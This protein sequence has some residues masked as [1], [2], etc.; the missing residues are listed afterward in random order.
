MTERQQQETFNDWIHAHRALLYKVIRSYAVDEDDQDD[1]FQE[2]IVQVWRS[3]PNFRNDCAVTT[4]M[5]RIALNTSM[6]W[7]NKT[8]RH[9]DNHQSLEQSSHIID[10]QPVKDDRLDW[11]Y[12]EISRLDKVDKSLTLLMLDGFSYKEMANI[13]GISETYV[14]VK[15]NR[16]KKHLI[17]RSNRYK[18]GI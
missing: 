4:W 1:L 10:L 16:I 5:Y 17:E 7:T 11:L 12:E 14:G 3:I 15:I 13:V 9:T 2:I 6:K 18:N 8:R